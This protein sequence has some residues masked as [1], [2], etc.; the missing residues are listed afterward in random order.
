MKIL[1]LDLST[2]TGWAVLNDENLLLGYGTLSRP[3]D[4]RELPGEYSN[5]TPEYTGIWKAGRVAKLIAPLLVKYSPDIIVI[6]RLPSGGFRHSKEMLYYIH[7]AVLSM[8]YLEGYQARVKYMEVSHWRSTLG[9]RLS[10]DQRQHN[11]KVKGHVARGKITWKHLSVNMANA[12]YGLS[13]KLKDNDASDSILIAKSFIIKMKGKN[14]ASK[15][16]LDIAKIF[17]MDGSSGSE[18]SQ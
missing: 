2:K 11:K 9:L 13:L 6:E 5:L 3:S 15:E 10:K 1:A 18:S 16:T 17:K 7:F 4:A 14:N 12:E 8:L